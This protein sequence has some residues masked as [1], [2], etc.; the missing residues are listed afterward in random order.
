MAA[1]PRQFRRQRIALI[2]FG[3]VARRLL[4]QRLTQPC[5][6]F[7]PRFIALSR[8]T[9]SLD[10]ASLNTVAKHQRLQFVHCD[11][12]DRRSV[13]RIRALGQS[14]LIFAP[15][16]DNKADTRDLRIR[17]LVSQLRLNQLAPRLVYISTTGVYGNAHGAVVTETS[18]CLTQQ[19]RSL[20]R[21]DAERQCRRLGAHV[22]RVP[23]IYAGD[24][25]PVERL[26]TQMPAL[27][28]E[29]DVY[30]NH[31]HADDLAEIT[32]LAC[33]RGHPG[34]I[35]NTVDQTSM[36]TGDYFDR[37]ADAKGYS[38]PP[39][40]SRAEMESLAQQGRISAMMMSFLKD[41]RQVRTKRL[42]QELGARL[43]YPTVD[44]TLTDTP[45]RERL[46]TTQR[47]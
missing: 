34:R 3:D 11:L 33:F 41:S 16:A 18:R 10:H 12:D 17:R 9:R 2:G 6:R 47:D 31:I 32:W 15:P 20:R 1:L 37:I 4:E 8:S 36:K 46:Q 26:R 25:L 27:R 7:G 5:A 40:I 22:L 35:T 43:R 30:T 21:I 44:H 28:P 24:R 14:V 45:T 39:R 38:R 42:E 19:P 29:D 13:K 23:G